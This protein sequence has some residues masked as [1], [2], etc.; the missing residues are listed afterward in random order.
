M[1]TTLIGTNWWNL[2]M[3]GQLPEFLCPAACVGT[4]D[5]VGLDYYWG[6]SSFAPKQLH[7]LIAAMSTNYGDAPVWPGGLGSILRE[8][9]AQ[10]PDKPII[11]VE[12][13]SVTSA[14]GIARADYI[15]EHVREVMDARKAGLPIVAYLCWSITSNREWGLPFNDSSDFGIYHVALDTDPD[16]ARVATPSA[17][18]YAEIIASYST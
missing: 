10:F 6:V 17:Q 7:R 2:G 15:A 5:Y 18:R 11:V 14:G 3:A 4:L 13:G 16:L 8:A 12:N 9:H 1:F